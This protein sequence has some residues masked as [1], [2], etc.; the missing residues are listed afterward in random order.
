MRFWLITVGEPVPLPGGQERL[1]RTGVLGGHLAR[2]GHEVTWWTSTVDHF[3]KRFHPVP[4][5]VLPVE[6]RYEIRFLPGRLYRSNVSLER[7]R[8]HREIARAFHATAASFPQPD[9][10]VCSLPPLELCVESVHFGRDHDIPVFL[11]VRDPWPDVFYRVLPRPLRR[12]G[13]LLFSPFVRQ[14]RSALQGATGILAVSEAYLSWGL[15]LA[16]R[17]P[18]LR[19]A[20]IT[21]GYPTLPPVSESDLTALRK[22]LGVRP[23]MTVLWFVGSFARH[24]DIGTIIDVAR[25][26]ADRH[27]L[28][29][30]LT[31]T[32]DRDAEWR[33]RAQGLDNVRFTGWVDWTAIARLARIASAGLV[34]Y[35]PDAPMTLTNKLF[36]YMS[37]GLPLLLGLAGEAE[38]IARE[39]DC[40]IVYRPGDPADLAR[41]VLAIAD[42]P[43]LR[44]R[45]A[46]GSTRAFQSAFAEDVIYPRFVALLEEEARKGRL[47]G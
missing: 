29:F 40:G 23:R 33:A 8:N 4:G 20:V 47:D 26:L 38:T 25:R 15:T 28:L 11:D 12:L 19:D 37:A 42:D 17:A 36:E 30:V 16:G 13:P 35:T 21:H 22:S 32:G 2:A 1:L 27:D 24:Y 3:R 46:A 45:L 14:A 34:S 41:A 39:W 6:P 43:E 44:G 31:G 7:L 18:G 10:I 9:L 5:P